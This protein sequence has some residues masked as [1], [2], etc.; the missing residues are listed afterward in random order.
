MKTIIKSILFVA[1]VAVTFSGCQQQAE[2]FDVTLKSSVTPV[3]ISKWTSGDAA[4]ECAQTTCDGPYSFKIDVWGDDGLN[5]SGEYETD[6]GNI[7]NII[8]GNEECKIDDAGITKCE[9][10]SFNW[11][12][13]NPVCAVIVDR[14]SV[15]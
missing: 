3:L 4:F 8:A 13:E 12:S 10:K 6:E 2:D 1:F 9:Y 11:E 15:V 14:K 7:F 5:P